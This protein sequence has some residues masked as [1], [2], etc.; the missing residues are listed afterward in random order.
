M[1]FTLVAAFTLVG[2]SSV[3]FGQSGP[4]LATVIDSGAKLRAGASEQFPD[5]ATLRQ[6]DRLLVDHEEP[7]GWLAVQDAPGKLYSLSW[8]QMQFLSEFDRNTPTPLNLTVVAD[9]TLAAGQIG[10][11]QPLTYFRKT[12]IPAGSILTVIGPKVTFEGKSWYPVVPPSGDFRYIAKQL[13]QM[14]KTANVSAYTVR[15]SSA[16]QLS[17]GFPPAA[18][19]PAGSNIPPQP[20]ATSPNIIGGPPVLPAVGTP[21]GNGSSTVPAITASSQTSGQPVVQ[22]PLWAQAEAAEKDGRLAAAEDLYFQLA[23]LMNEPGG[24]HDVANMCYT[25]IHS[26]REKTKKQTSTSGTP[27]STPRTTTV[28]PTQS[29]NANL[30]PTVG[31]ASPPVGGNLKPGVIA[32]GKLTRSVLDIDGRKTFALE[33]SMGLRLAYVVAGQGV[34]LERYLNKWIDVYGS[35]TTRK[36]A[37]KPVVVASSVESAK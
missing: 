5:T 21:V 20:F 37:S 31:V 13:V 25:R 30:T 22:N 6:G 4:Y 7:N 23:R 19:T 8:I 35:S 28:N 14:D 12:K 3:A 34:D 24:D 16:T 36:D 9:T 2:V 33:D 27:T 11:T 1:R 10:V 26:L 17:N 18:I 29:V 15:E 32:S